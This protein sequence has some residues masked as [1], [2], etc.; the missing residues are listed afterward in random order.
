VSGEGE[1]GSKPL[2]GGGGKMGFEPELGLYNTIQ[3]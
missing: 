2:V 1:E 3:S